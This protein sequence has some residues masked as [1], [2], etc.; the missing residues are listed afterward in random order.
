MAGLSGSLNDG[1]PAAREQSA[2][3]C[4][5]AS[6]HQPFTFTNRQSPCTCYQLPAGLTQSIASIH[7]ID[8]IHENDA[9]YQAPSR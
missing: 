8:N 3:S 2:L 7:V 6:I 1:A 9:R 4:L 5:H